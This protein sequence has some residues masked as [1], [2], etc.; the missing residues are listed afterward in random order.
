MEPH[1]RCR[2][3]VL[4]TLT[5]LIGAAGTAAHAGGDSYRWVDDEG[6]VHYGDSLPPTVRGGSH[7]R[8]DASGEVIET[9]DATLRAVDEVAEEQA[10]EDAPSQNERDR[11]L[12][13]SFATERDIIMTR[14]D[15]LAGV[16]IQI[17][18]I[19]RR[20]DQLEER[21]AQTDDAEREAH[22]N[23]RLATQ[24]Q[25]LDDYRER[26]DTIAMRFNADLQRFRELTQ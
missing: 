3:V 10:G 21:L 6:N 9:F 13:Q 2:S 7:S 1:A 20:I 16:D 22:L 23:E 19:E 4:G 14:D 5:L 11:I 8:L 24:Q 18:L 26:R 15:R 25:A 17:T 12:L